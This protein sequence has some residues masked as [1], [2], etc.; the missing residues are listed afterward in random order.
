MTCLQFE[1]HSG[2]GLCQI[3]SQ[4][5]QEGLYSF[6]PRPVDAFPEQLHP[7]VKVVI[8]QVQ[9]VQ[10]PLMWVHLSTDPASQLKL[11][12]SGFLPFALA[13]V[14]LFSNRSVLICFTFFMNYEVTTTIIITITIKVIL[15]ISSEPVRKHTIGCILLLQKFRIIISGIIALITYVKEFHQLSLAWSELVICKSFIPRL[16]IIFKIFTM[17]P[18]LKKCQHCST[19]VLSITSVTSRQ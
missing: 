15:V 2:L 13:F 12:S 4:T 5:V 18:W 16:V 9:F 1:H 10:S 8:P 19:V 7:I 3:S 14:D 17:P 11:Q 6:Q